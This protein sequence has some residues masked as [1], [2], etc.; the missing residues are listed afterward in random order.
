MIFVT[1]RVLFGYLGHHFGSQELIVNI[2]LPTH[3]VN[4]GKLSVKE[5]LKVENYDGQIQGSVNSL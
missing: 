4:W 1:L 5:I 2:R 3:L